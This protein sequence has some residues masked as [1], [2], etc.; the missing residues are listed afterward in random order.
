MMSIERG[1]HYGLNP[2]GRRIW[3]WIAE[4]R[5]VS[6]LV[7]IAGSS[8]RRWALDIMVPTLSRK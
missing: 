5:S 2:V 7:T 8:P 4:E 1:F 3:E 6:D